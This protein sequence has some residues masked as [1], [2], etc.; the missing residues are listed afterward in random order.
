MVLSALSCATA[1]WLP[2]LFLGLQRG[3]EPCSEL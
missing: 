3:A 1:R 2:A